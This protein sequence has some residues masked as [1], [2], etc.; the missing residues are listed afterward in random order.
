MSMGSTIFP[1]K[2]QYG[3]EEEWGKEEIFL[4][5]LWGGEKRIS[6]LRAPKRKNRHKIGNVKQ[7]WTANRNISTWLHR[8]KERNKP[9][10]KLFSR[11][12]FQLKFQE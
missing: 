5:D 11:S 12:I 3:S 9:Q 6:H 7:G 4:R 2:G 8:G 10:S 1:F